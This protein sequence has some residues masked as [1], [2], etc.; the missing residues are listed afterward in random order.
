MFDMF[1]THVAILLR[2]T[3]KADLTIKAPRNLLAA[4]AQKYSYNVINTAIRW[5]PSPYSAA[6]MGC[7]TPPQYAFRTLTA[8]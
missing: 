3:L 6:C 4:I 8:T 1:H 7:C 5:G 2:G